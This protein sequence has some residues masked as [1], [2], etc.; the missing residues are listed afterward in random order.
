[1]AFLKSLLFFLLAGCV[2]CFADILLQGEPIFEICDSQL[3]VNLN[4][5]PVPGSKGYVVS[6]ESKKSDGRQQKQEV[7]SNKAI[8][9]GISEDVTYAWRVQPIGRTKKNILKPLEGGTFLSPIASSLTSR[10]DVPYGFL[11]LST[12]DA[13]PRGAAVAPAKASLA[14][15]IIGENSFAQVGTPK[16]E[17][18]W[19]G[20]ALQVRVTMMR[21]NNREALSKITQ[22]D[23]PIWTDDD[24][25]V[26]I[27]PP[28][29]RYYY[30]FGANAIGT[31]FD[32]KNTDASWNG[33]WKSEARLEENAL[34]FLI[35]IPWKT[36]QMVPTPGKEFKG[37]ITATFGVEHLTKTWSETGVPHQ[38]EKFDK[39]MLLPKKAL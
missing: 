22:R 9:H 35:S 17:M 29:D 7:N 27:Q 24:V 33:E 4:W 5:T 2:S 20:D 13:A 23:G 3:S 38:P 16:A 32:G 6:I 26:F 21:P 25:E 31:Q 36:L 12:A 14:G 19:N 10:L 34:V 11:T 30:Q 1:L 8:F 15:S 37:N 18:V 39:L 28:E